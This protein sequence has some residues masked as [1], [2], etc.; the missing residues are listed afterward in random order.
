VLDPVDERAE[1][2][3]GVERGTR[4]G[5][6]WDVVD[7]VRRPRAGVPEEDDIVEGIWVENEQLTGPD[8]P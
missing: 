5:N 4:Y 3:G 8:R 1:V 6:H 7:E 2:F